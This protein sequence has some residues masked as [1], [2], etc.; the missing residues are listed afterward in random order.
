M[1]KVL[2]AFRELPFFSGGDQHPGIWSADRGSLRCS[3]I[4]LQDGSLCLYSP[5]S[6]L[7][8]AARASLEAIGEVSFLLA[9]N[10]YH[11]KGLAEYARVFP[12]ASRV[13]SDAA[14]PRLRA[15]T[16][17]TFD[18]LQDLARR[19]PEGCELA[20]PRG[21]KTGEVWLD[22]SVADQR[23]WVVTDAFKGPAR[24]SDEGRI[25]LL[26]TFPRYGIDSRET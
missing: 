24:S 26:G 19:L 21:L 25:E 17:L 8:D 18:G 23:I 11:H 12:Q 13:C 15:Q 22:L 16:E 5:V 4:R 20:E 9:P 6:G 14:R 3:A 2:S 1:S 10:H 7:G